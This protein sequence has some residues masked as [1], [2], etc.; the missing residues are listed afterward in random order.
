MTPEGVF[1]SHLKGRGNHF[2]GSWSQIVPGDK[3]K[4]MKWLSSSGPANSGGSYL[5]DAGRRRFLLEHRV[6]YS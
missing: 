5:K 2:G 6:K 3:L 1:Q 4:R